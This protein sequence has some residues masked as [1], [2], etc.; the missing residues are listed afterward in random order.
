MPSGMEWLVVLAIGLLLFGKRLPEVG[1]SLGQGI[2]EFK[3]GL[4]DVEGSAKDGASTTPTAR[5]NELPSSSAQSSSTS[6]RS[7][8][9]TH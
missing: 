3:K 4:K 8:T 6:Q 5:P 7:E 9:S 1:R 2:N